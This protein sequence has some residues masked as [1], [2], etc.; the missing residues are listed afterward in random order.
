MINSHPRYMCFPSVVRVGRKTE[1]SVRPRDISRVF[2]DDKEYELCVIG[3]RDD[4][5]NYFDPLPKE[6]E[7][8]VSDGCL[9]FT[10][11]FPKEQEY[12][13]RFCEK[14][15]KET[16]ISLYAV[17]DDLYSR[18]AL[19]GDLHC[20]SFYSDGQDGLAMTPADYREEGFDFFALTD[21][22]RMYTSQMAARLYENVPI[23]LNIIQGEE[24]HTPGSVMHIVH[25]GGRTSVCNKYIKEPEVYESA[26][27][28]I[29]K[30]LNHIP[31]QYR[32]R[33]AMA[34]YACDEIHKAGGIAIFA[35][36]F[37]CPNIYNLS[38]EFCDI[39]FDEKIFDAFEVF[40]GINQKQNNLQLNLWQEQI[41]KGN[42]IPVVASSDSHNHDFA[43]TGFARR[44]SIV[45]A[46]ENSTEA[47]IKAIKEGYSVAAEIPMGNN[48]EIRFC[49]AQ[50]RLVAFA[51]FLYENYFSETYRLC[52]GEGI[53]MRR[54][55]EG[56]D[57]T[58][59]LKLLKGTVNKFYK[60]F[61]GLEKYDKLPK[62]RLNFLDE[63][64]TLQ[65]QV[66]PETCGSQLRIYGSNIRRE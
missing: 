16:R 24:V 20:H 60:R 63:C 25:I 32:K 8:T 33:V 30:K 43:K 40:G 66:G 52:M 12:S 17:E 36:P 58:E 34:H 15:G 10:Y 44:F 41:L 55:A 7:H 50:L 29:E 21:H 31:E 56:E 2:R 47:I 59:E 22:N 57:V 3:M 4:M 49:S 5:V 46:E 23:D 39:L 42:K 6:C 54:F 64:R 53:L 19:K 9:H 27:S 13:I 51:H 61:Y 65:Q 1:I 14:G 38:E 37:W 62:E 18:M 11:T 45:F 48:E 28:E 26:V 35:H